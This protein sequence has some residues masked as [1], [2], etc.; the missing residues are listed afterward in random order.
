MGIVRISTNVLAYVLDT[1]NTLSQLSHFLPLPF[2]CICSCTCEGETEVVL[3]STL[4]LQAQAGDRTVCRELGSLVPWPWQLVI[5]SFHSGLLRNALCSLLPGVLFPWA[6]SGPSS[7]PNITC[8]SSL[9]PRLISNTPA[10][11]PWVSYP[12]TPHVNWLRVT[13]SHPGLNSV[14]P[15]FMCMQNPRRWHY[16]VIGSS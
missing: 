11:L 13:P 2:S 8:G 16:L 12:S 7:I 6:Q 15:K 4:T 14:T 9:S 1:V 5:W 10:L 3:L